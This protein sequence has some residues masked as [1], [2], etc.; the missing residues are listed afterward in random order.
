MRRANGTGSVYKRRDV[1]RRKPW[2]AVVNLGFTDKGKRK[3]KILGSFTTAKEAQLALEKWNGN[4]INPST[5]T[6]GEI[7]EACCLARKRNNKPLPLINRSAWNAHVSKL[8]DYPIDTIKTIHLQKILDTSGL[9]GGSMPS[10]VTVMREIFDYAIGNDLATKDYTNFLKLPSAQKSHKH[11][12]MSDDTL[13][14]LW[15]NVLNDGVKFVLIQVYTGMRAGELAK[16]KRKD[17]DLPHRMMVGGGKT[18]AG[19]NR[20]I[21]IAKCITPLVRHFLD[22]S[23]LNKCEYLIL[24][25]AERGL[26]CLHDRVTPTGL[27]ER[28]FLNAPS[29]HLSHDARHTFITKMTR[30]DCKEHILKAIVGHAQK[31]IT[32]EVYT[33]ITD[34]ELIEAIDLFPS[35][36]ELF[37]GSHVVATQ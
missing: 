3:K 34:A 17:V 6:V 22:I 11:K 37:S 2:V 21:P 16:M 24:P 8:K 5:I 32:K 13:R 7:W 4:P 31:G 27:Y 12:V 30:T 36:N 25:D 15:E 35:P 33:H 28:V 14:Y 29:E 18:K 19:T 26:P 23:I 20:R 9:S 1:K 10:L